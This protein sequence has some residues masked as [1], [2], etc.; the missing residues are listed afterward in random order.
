MKANG[1]LVI[2]YKNKDP[3]DDALLNV[4]D[5]PNMFIEIPTLIISNEDG[6]NLIQMLNRKGMIKMRFRIPIK[7]HMNFVTLDWYF[8]LED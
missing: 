2:I 3:L 1:S 5:L 4:N 6:Q 7:T 8:K